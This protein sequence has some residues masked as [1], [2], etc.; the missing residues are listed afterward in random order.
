MATFDVRRLYLRNARSEVFNFMDTGHFLVNPGGLGASISL[1]TV[2]LGNSEMLTGKDYNLMTF[3]GEI[4]FMGTREEVYQDYRTFIKFL[5][6]DYMR[7]CYQPVGEEKAFYC[8][9]EVSA[10]TKTEVNNRDSILHVPIQIKCLEFWRKTPMVSVSVEPT[11]MDGK[12]YPL[13]RKLASDPDGVGYYYHKNDFKKVILTNNGD[14]ETPLDIIVRND[15]VRNFTYA[16]YEYTGD[17]DDIDD[18]EENYSVY[19]MGRILGTYR[20]IEVNADD[21]EENIVLKTGTN[22]LANT[23]NYQDLS[24]GSP[25]EIYVTFLKLKP[26]RN[27]ITLNVG[28]DFTGEVLIRYWEMF[29]TV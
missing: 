12:V 24:V 27:A 22:T 6:T 8:R 13:Y 3:T 21:L 14:V 18:S 28:D 19:G 23:Y 26:G 16:L 2:R 25:N 1:P 15:T 7:L 29:Y 11:E 10:I 5:N 17:L 9:A 20:Y 4:Y